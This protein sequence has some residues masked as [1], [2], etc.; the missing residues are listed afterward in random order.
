M[1]YLL[2]RDQL[3]VIL[4]SI[5]FI[6]YVNKLIPTPFKNL[7][8]PSSTL[9]TTS[10]LSPDYNIRWRKSHQFVKSCI[11]ATLIES[12]VSQIQSLKLPQLRKLG[13]HQ[14][15]SFTI[16]LLLVNHTLNPNSKT[17]KNGSHLLWITCNSLNLQLMHW[18]PLM[19]ESRT[20]TWLTMP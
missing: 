1:I 15:N 2:Q 3:E 9:D 16:N 12:I 14:N 11:N 18:L 19:I 10:T 13:T 7:H 17:L 5:D 8:V 6:G 4:I 20:L